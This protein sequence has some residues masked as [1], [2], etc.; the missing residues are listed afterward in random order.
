[1]NLVDYHLLGYVPSETDFHR[2]I[3]AKS[4]PA[5]ALYSGEN[6]LAQSILKMI[7]YGNE[8]S[9]RV[10]KR[11]LANGSAVSSN[12]Q[13]RKDVAYIH[14][15]YFADIEAR[16]QPPLSDEEVI[17]RLIEDLGKSNPRVKRE[18]DFLLASID[19][20]QTDEWLGVHNV[21]FKL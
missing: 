10:Y 21:V 14:S 5:T 18:L 8:N 12:S 1:M 17:E 7:D 3:H 9:H 2:I 20:S 16:N 19:E 6:Q 11:Q 13:A 4:A 15:K